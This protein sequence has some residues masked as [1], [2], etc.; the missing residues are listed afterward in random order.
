MLQAVQVILY[1]RDQA[2][3]RRFYA[4]VL[5]AEPALDV[6]GMTAFELGSIRLGL[7]PEAGAERR[8]SACRCRR[9]CGHPRPSPPVDHAPLPRH[10]HRTLGS[11][12][13]PC[14]RHQRNT[15]RDPVCR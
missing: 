5:A 14:G 12:R 8:G 11:A 1:V 3:S 15:R 6:P 10:P 7:M 9:G 13:H 4:E 2:S